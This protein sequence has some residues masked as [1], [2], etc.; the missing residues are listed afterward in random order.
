M[1]LNYNH[2]YY[3][4]V[5]ASEGAVAS[6]ATRLGVT[7]PTVSEQVKTLERALRVSLFERTTAGL[8]LTDAGRLAFE[9]TSVMFRA[10]ERLVESLGHDATK[11]PRSLRVGISSA[12]SRATTTDFLMPLLALEN[13]VPSIRTGDAVELLRD[14]R[15]SALDLVLLEAEPPES[16]RRGLEVVLIDKTTLLAVGPPGTE[17]VDDWQGLS[18][19]H[20]RPTSAF[21]WEVEAYLELMGLRPRIAAEADDPL[22]LVEAAARGGFVAFVPRSVARDSVQSGRLTILATVQTTE[23]GVHALYPEGETAQLAKRA[24][25]VLIEHVRAQTG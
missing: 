3:F 23:A 24:V 7:Q 1:M 13:C 5:V 19:I 9:Q 17:P 18:L 8:K 21:R 20:Y 25:E 12:V 15:G 2:L 10:G 6:A 14:L 11:M 22:F 16:T 4:H